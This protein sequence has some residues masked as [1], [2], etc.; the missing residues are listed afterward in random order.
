MQTDGCIAWPPSANIHRRACAALHPSNRFGTGLDTS[1]G[2]ACEEEIIRPAVDK[3]M[4]PLGS[5]MEF[6]QAASDCSLSKLN[7]C[8]GRAYGCCWNGNRISLA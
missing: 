7:A 4:Q 2:H 3:T 5:L 8:F 6:D 1:E